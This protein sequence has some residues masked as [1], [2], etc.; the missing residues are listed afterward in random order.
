MECL[1]QLTNLKLG[2]GLREVAFSKVRL[3]ESQVQEEPRRTQDANIGTVNSNSTVN[4][5]ETHRKASSTSLLQSRITC[6]G[7]S[8]NAKFE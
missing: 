2:M 6:S 7:G 4:G 8:Y 1:S 3:P 5:I